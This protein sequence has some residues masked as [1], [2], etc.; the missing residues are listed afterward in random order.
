MTASYVGATSSPVGP[1]EGWP[2]VECAG[3]W[4]YVAPVYLAPVARC[5]VLAACDAWECDLPSRDLVDAIWRAADVRLDPWR[6]TRPNTLQTG[7][8]WAAYVDQRARIERAIDGRSGLVVGTH[9][10]FAL[11]DGKRID[12]YGW[13]DLTGRVIEPGRT[14][15]NEAHVDYSQGLRLVRRKS[16]G[17]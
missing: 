8:S 17:E 7:A 11:L 2:V 15:H 10:D 16:T 3:E 14:S 12:L 9:K 4:W 6:L 13:H 5:D 1:V